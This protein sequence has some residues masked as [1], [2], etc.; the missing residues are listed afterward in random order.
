MENTELLTEQSTDLSTKKQEKNISVISNDSEICKSNRLIESSYR[1]TTAENRLLY[2]GMSKLKIYILNK[3]TNIEQVKKAMESATF[4]KIRIDVIEYKNRFH[5]KSN[6]LYKQLSDMTKQLFDS[7]IL[8]FEGENV[9]QTRWLTWC[10]YDDKA[11]AVEIKFNPE[12]IKDLLVIKDRFTRMLFENFVHI[13]KKYSF[14]IY[15]LCKQYLNIGYRTFYLEDL[16]FKLGIRDDEYRKYGAFK[17]QV[18]SSS[19]DEINTYTDINISLD[20]IGKD[21]KTRKVIRIKFII[22]RNKNKITKKEC[23]QLS[24]LNDNILE[25]DTAIVEKLSNIIQ[26][27]LTAG[28]AENILITALNSIEKYKL[29]IGVTDYIKEKV[30]I[31]N[32]YSLHNVISNPV[33]LLITALKNNWKKNGTNKSVL[34]NGMTL[35]ELEQQLTNHQD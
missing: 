35:K 24:F 13:R 16:R 32:N 22:K 30:S 3:N 10:K 26:F 21:K 14:R 23:K 27:E 20:E 29:N 25:E 1:L 4:D 34:V 6:N 8:Y 15:E 17:K 28:E 2:M 12:L 33:G 5:I 31:C 18:L 9:V 7:Q 19:I 11:K